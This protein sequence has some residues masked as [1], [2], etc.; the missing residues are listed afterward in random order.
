MESCLAARADELAAK[1][2]M[3]CIECLTDT[4]I[5]SAKLFEAQY[6]LCIPPREPCRAFSAS[7]RVM[8]ATVTLCSPKASHEN[9]KDCSFIPIPMEPIPKAV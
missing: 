3:R 7:L 9:V 5:S 8:C 1:R 2:R 6:A 4:C